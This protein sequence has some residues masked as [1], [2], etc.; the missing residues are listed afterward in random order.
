MTYRRLICCSTRCH[1]SQPTSP[2]RLATGF[3][4]MRGRGF[5]NG[6]RRRFGWDDRQLGIDERG[7]RPSVGFIDRRCHVGLDERGEHVGGPG[8]RKRRLRVE[9]GTGGGLV[10]RR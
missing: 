2:C 8:E 7:L 9:G 3:E 5:R 10:L 6:R 1:A 4:R